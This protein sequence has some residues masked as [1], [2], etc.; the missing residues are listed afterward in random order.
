MFQVIRHVI[1]APDELR[2]NSTTKEGYLIVDTQTADTEASSGQRE[3]FVWYDLNLLKSLQ[4][5]S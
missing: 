5:E 2:Y 1:K 4:Q 3:I